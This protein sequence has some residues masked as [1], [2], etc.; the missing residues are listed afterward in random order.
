MNKP[1]KQAVRKKLDLRL[2]LIIIGSVLVTALLSIAIAIAITKSSKP[3]EKQPAD[4]SN[5]DVKKKFSCNRV[6]E[7]VRDTDIFCDN[8]EYF[9][10]TSVSEEDYKKMLR[11]DERNTPEGKELPSYTW[12]MN[13]EIATEICSDPEK[14][15]RGHQEFIEELKWLSD[16]SNYEDNSW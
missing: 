11:C 10:D 4:Y 16:E 1:S 8:P 5:E 13:P 15:K 7:E 12:R 3:T 14:I 2:I 6:T 9:R